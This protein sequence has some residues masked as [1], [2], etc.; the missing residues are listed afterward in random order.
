[1]LGEDHEMDPGSYVAI[2]G[3]LVSAKSLISAKIKAHLALS[4]SFG[5]YGRG[6]A[7]AILIQI[8]I[9]RQ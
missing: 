8:L 1:M 4:I 3:P 2:G 7:N 6:Q 5:G 9:K